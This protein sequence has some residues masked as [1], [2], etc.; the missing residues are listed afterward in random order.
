MRVSEGGRAAGKSRP[1]QRPVNVPNP[2]G[3]NARDQVG[4]TVGVSGKL[5]DH[6]TKFFCA[7]NRPGSTSYRADL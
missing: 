5:I 6:A 1:K 4:K 7:R 2:N 3:G